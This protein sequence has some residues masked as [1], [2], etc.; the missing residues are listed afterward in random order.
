MLT[1]VALSDPLGAPAGLEGGP[2]AREAPKGAGG[3]MA[4]ARLVQGSY[5]NSQMWL[6]GAVSG[7]KLLSFI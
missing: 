3:F 7:R 4:A 1:F 6:C 5:V 2:Q